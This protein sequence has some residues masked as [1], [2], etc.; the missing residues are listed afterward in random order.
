MAAEA[1]QIVARAIGWSLADDE[2]R[3]AVD[4]AEA[5]RGL[6]LASVVLSG[7]VEAI[8]REAGQPAAA[9]AWHSGSEAG[10]AT[11]LTAL[12]DTAD[13]GSL[14]STPIGEGISLTLVGTPFDAVVYLMPPAAPDSAGA[15]TDH[16]PEPMGHAMLIRPVFGQIEVVPLPGLAGLGSGT[17]LDAYLVALDRALSGHDPRAANDE[18]FRSGPAGKD[19]ADE[20]ENLGQ[21]T[22]ATIMAP[23]LEHIRG[24]SLDHLPHLALIPLGELAT[25]PFAAS[26]TDRTPRG[27]R[28][29]A[30]DD[31][32]LTYAASARLLGE[33]A[34][35]PR[36]PLFERVVLVSDPAGELHM[37]RRA[38]RR[39]GRRQYPSAEVYGLKSDRNGPATCRA[40]LDALPATDRPGASLL[41]LSTHGRLTPTPALLAQDGWLPLSSILDQARDRPPDAPG[42][43]VITNACLTDT[44]QGHFDESLTMATAFLAAGATGVVGT[45]WPVDD[46]TAAA[47]CLRLHYHL[48]R[49]YQP[50]EALQRAQLDLLR[51]TADTRATLGPDLDALTDARLSHPATWAG[52]VHHGI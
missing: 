42:G 26:W 24:W 30:I 3:A 2:H 12:W 35:R 7:R 8:L 27:E 46:D 41:Q 6:V 36:Q 4:I 31:A 45:R 13:G 22:Y 33:V 38:T 10:R 5:G 34:R 32:V 44:A 49:G 29:Y 48:Q 16:G 51:P 40:L 1:N 15:G 39:L 25:I 43:L 17:P 18:G 19:W 21:W 28:R 50:A 20:L 52:H 47:L 9:D 23:L 11:A 37:T 14:L